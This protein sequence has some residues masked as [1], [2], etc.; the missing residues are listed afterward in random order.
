MIRILSMITLLLAIMLA[1]EARADIAQ[2]KSAAV[3]F[4]YQR[5]GEDALPSA[6]LSTDLFEA[7]LRELAAG[8][9]NVMPLPDIVAALKAGNELPA[10]TIGLTFDGA[11]KST[12]ENA[13]PRL[14]KYGFP[15]TIF[16]STDMADRASPD[17]LGWK[18]LKRLSKKKT[19]TLGILPAA[20][21]HMSSASAAANDASMNK[22]VTRFREQIG[23]A[24]ALFAWPY[25]EYTP[26]LKS[27]IE[28]YGFTA[29]FGQQ[30]GVSY[31]GSDFLSLPRFVMTDDYGD[32]ERF[33]MTASA[34]PLPIGDIIPAGTIIDTNPP[35][36]GFSVVSSI[37]D[38]KSL[39]CFASGVGKVPLE[40]LGDNR[41]EL[42]LKD[43][44]IE[45]R[46]RINCTLP[47]EITA[48]AETPVWR[49][50]G[51]L[52]TNAPGIDEAGNAGNAALPIVEPDPAGGGE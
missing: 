11:Y 39:S 20:Y 51:M 12:L 44:L 22:A 15:Y 19:V 10:R 8:K 30:S 5:I 17:E 43:I 26:A 25:G 31:G 9:Y 29:A 7:H 37:K 16:I 45:D 14:E 23:S 36:I 32:L 6:N 35:K 18:E 49:W 47:A 50:H 40:I 52:F 33:R 28:K 1:P 48:P 34:L 4:A 38:L 41:V 46:V 42:A 21:T 3:I 24:S 2:D 13:I 27:A